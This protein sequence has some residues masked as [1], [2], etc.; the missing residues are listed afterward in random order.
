MAKRKT[1]SAEFKEEVLELLAQPGQTVAGVARDLGLSASMVNRWRK[2]KRELGRQ[3]F[4]GQGVSR[5]E[6]LT[7]LKRELAK[8]TKERD[9]LRDAAA[10][11]AKLEK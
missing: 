1:Y 9:F 10:Y 2:E 3:A 4:V 6:E 7:R 5:D 8:V 11:F